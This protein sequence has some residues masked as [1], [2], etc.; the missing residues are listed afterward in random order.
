MTLEDCKNIHDL[1]EEA[2]KVLDPW[3]FEYLIGG[4]DDL[5]TVERNSSA[6]E[7]YQIRPRRL[8]DVSQVST[9][10]NVLGKPRATP[11]F[12]APVG[13]QK[14]FHS[15]AELA[16]AKGSNA[17]GNQLILSTLSS[18]SYPEIAQ[19]TE[20]QPWFQLY[21]TNS[22][23]T[24]KKLLQ[25]AEEAGAEV[26]VL[27]VDVPVVGNRESHVDFLNQA[28]ESLGDKSSNLK[29]LVSD[30][31]TFND[32]TLTWD[33]ID[34]VRENCSMKI[35]IKGIMTG[36][37]TEL[38]L[39]KKVDGIIVSNHGGRQL[40]SD[41]STIEALP[42]VVAA[43]KGKIPV[44]LDGGIHRGTDIFKAL[45]LGAVAVCIGR[46]FC[47]GLAAFGQ[48]G[49]ERALQILQ[50]EFERCMR[51]SGVTTLEEIGPGFIQGAN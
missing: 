11:I 6:F 13:L 46:A 16:T 38:C 7:K 30:D 25:I 17:L 32:P 1:K 39:R 26:V 42:E 29:G 3:P 9:E 44:M 45:A 15:D 23:S 19:E 21:P 8:V 28:T 10:V 37:D 5:R 22:L 2:S 41:L 49:V 51:L 47:Y 50:A 18:Y 35:V 27:T 43:A 36:V 4:A 12:I 34:W 48:P 33:Y 24:R 20:I 14:E 31:F 40:E